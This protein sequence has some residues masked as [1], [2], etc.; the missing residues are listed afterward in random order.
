[1]TEL[2]LKYSNYLIDFPHLKAIPNPDYLKILQVSFT[3][4]NA[5]HDYIKFRELNV[6]TNEPIYELIIPPD[7]MDW[8]Y[9]EHDIVTTEV[10]I[11]LSHKNLFIPQLNLL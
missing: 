1:L 6:D 9:K 4:E 10:N 8:Y 7:N 2:I 11:P 5:K 3:N